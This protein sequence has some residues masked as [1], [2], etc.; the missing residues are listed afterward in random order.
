MKDKLLLITG[1]S[2]G[3]G[4]AIVLEAIN[5]GYKVAFTYNSNKDEALAFLDEIGDKEVEAFQFTLGKRDNVKRLLLDI[6][7]RFG[8][9]PSYLVNNAAI[10]IQKDFETISDEEWDLVLNTNLTGVFQIVQE[11]IVDMKK[12]NFGRIVNISSIGGQVGGNLAVH[13]ATTKAGLISFSKS[14][15]KIYSKYNV[16]TN[17][18][19]P[20]LVNTKMIE[21]ELDSDAGK[22]KLKTIPVG[23]ITEPEEIANLVLFLL[24]EKNTTMTGQTVNI[25]GGMYFG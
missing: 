24:S 25:N 6:E 4:K 14:M 17:C 23:K 18:I 22:E 12:N 21:K 20:G 5:A 7:K 13:Y 16:L 1:G 8:Q 15:A 9:F 11:L 19:A 3:I 10:L 2:Q